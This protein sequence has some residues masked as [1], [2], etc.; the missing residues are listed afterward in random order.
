MIM[1]NLYFISLTGLSLML[2]LSFGA[3]AAEPPYISP[4]NDKTA[5]VGEPFILD[6]DAMD[7]DPAET[8]ELLDARPGMTIDPLTGVIN[9]TPAAPDE[10]GIVSVRAYNSEGESSRS[11]YIYV[12]DE[13]ICPTN[14]VSYWKLDDASDSI[15]MDYTGGYTAKSLSPLEDIEGV[16]NRAKQ[17]SPVGK[18]DTFVNVPDSGQ[19]DFPYLCGSIT[20]DSI[21]GLIITRY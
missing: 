6:I 5:A 21:P 19:Y 8:Y 18:I 16:V 4:I 2:F 15:Y 17:F 13:I 11:F 20:R 14:L 9:W 12:T 10:G 1:K 3:S 7:A